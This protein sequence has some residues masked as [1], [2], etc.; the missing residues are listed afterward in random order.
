M[1]DPRSVRERFWEMVCS[2]YGIIRLGFSLTVVMFLLSLFSFLY[3]EPGSATYA[4]L[5]VDLVLLAVSFVVL[6][7]PLYRCRSE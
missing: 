7:I 5:Q 2:A 1:G 3:V 4:I 6:S